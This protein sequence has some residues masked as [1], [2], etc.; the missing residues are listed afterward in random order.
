MSAP[1]TPPGLVPIVIVARLN[2]LRS[3]LASLAS[4]SL[5]CQTSRRA[6]RTCWRSLPE[7]KE[8]MAVARLPD[9]VAPPETGEARGWAGGLR[10]VYWKEKLR[11]VLPD[12]MAL[13]WR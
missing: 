6:T 12:C 9:S 1:K 7:R 10:E 13:T 8:R 3:A 4:H 11:A 2:S 5:P